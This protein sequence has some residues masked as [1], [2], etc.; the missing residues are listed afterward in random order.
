MI[1][2]Y[3]TILHTASISSEQF[4]FQLIFYW[5]I[6]L[7]VESCS[8]KN[9]ECANSYHENPP[10]RILNRFLNSTLWK[11]RCSLNLK[12]QAVNKAQRQLRLEPYF[13]EFFKSRAQKTIFRS[14]MSM[15]HS[16]WAVLTG[17]FY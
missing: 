5:R 15:R 11:I 1:K 6:K 17:P 2:E 14:P 10:N 8:H 13:H 4:S 12:A 7:N 9:P 3:L 16:S